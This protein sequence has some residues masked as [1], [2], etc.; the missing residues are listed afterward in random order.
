MTLVEW[1]QTVGKNLQFIEAGAEMA[2]RHARMLPFKPA[3]ETKAK[4]ELT[5]ARK[6]LES[7]LGSILAAEAVYEAKPIGNES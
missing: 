2:A 1:D 7:A 5:A 4:E 6:V 3:F